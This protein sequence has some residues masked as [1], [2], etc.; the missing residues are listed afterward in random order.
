MNIRGIE[1]AL[2]EDEMLSNH[3]RETRDFFEADILDYIKEHYPQQKTIVDVG[4]NIGNHSIYFANFLKYEAI[5]CF[6][7]VPENF[8]LLVKNMTRY[9]GIGMTGYALSNKA[10]TL[11]MRPN[12][13]NM[14]ASQVD[15]NGSLETQCYPLDWFSLQDV[16]LLKIDVEWHEPE[17]LS[18]AQ[19]TIWRSHPLI[20]IEDIENRYGH[21]LPDYTLEAGWPQHSTY[22][23]KWRH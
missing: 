14:G 7:P 12:R 6:E 20:L 22:L 3:I 1:V 21:L 19:D 2:H 23:Y 15:E 16:T 9:S 4:A 11:R 13:E 8:D 10:G 17:V 5:L 18:G